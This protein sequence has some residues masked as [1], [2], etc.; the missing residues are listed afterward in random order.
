MLL[1]RFFLLFA[2]LT[3]AATGFS[4]TS[5]PLAFGQGRS[6][7]LTSP[8]EVNQYTLSGVENGDE[9]LIRVA[10]AG[11]LQPVL[12]V[13]YGNQPLD[14]IEHA[15]L[16]EWTTTAIHSGS[17][18]LR[19][20]DQ[21]ADDSGMFSICA[22][23]LNRP[24][25]PEIIG[26]NT[27]LAGYLTYGADIKAFKIQLED[28][29]T[30]SLSVFTV[31]PD[32]IHPRLIV[33]DPTGVLLGSCS[34]ASACSILLDSLPAS[35]YYLF[36][37]DSTGANTGVFYLEITYYTGGCV[38]KE[39]AITSS[40]D[41]LIVIPGGSAIV[42]RPLCPGDDFTLTASYDAP[43]ALYQWT[44]PD[45]F[46]AT[47]AEFARTDISGQ[48]GGWYTVS[49]YV[50]GGC[51][52]TASFYLDVR[53]PSVSIDVSPGDDGVVCAG[54][55][56]TLAVINPVSTNYH[57]FMPNGSTIDGPNIVI[58][59]IDT[60]QAG[61]YRVSAYFPWNLPYING[62][63]V[64]TGEQL[65]TVLPAPTVQAIVSG[66]DIIPSASGG[67]G[68]Y[69]YD[70]T[71]GY[72]LVDGRFQNLPQGH[73]VITVTDANGC[74]ATSD[75]LVVAVAEPSAAFGLTLTPNPG[76]GIFRLTCTDL[77]RLPLHLSLYDA[78]GLP[79]STFDLH[80]Q[81]LTLDLSDLPSGWY[82]I[83]IKDEM[84]V[85]ALRLG[86]VR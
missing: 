42:Q 72:P 52:S 84:Q 51:Q 49:A 16:A 6:D 82:L 85:G 71:G 40:T 43:D 68:P 37:M 12:E 58:A 79:L 47:G 38:D 14:T 32:A 13:W 20:R 67:A 25:E 69:S 3:V 65:I 1:K 11:S 48:A 57:W 44:G 27:G 18:T 17:Y 60:L 73:Y 7:S 23:R 55:D 77:L 86:I 10:S 15:F 80:H 83:R 5:Q 9:L 19:V 22:Q 50:P 30:V 34:A 39:V 46:T 53:N 76:S 2:W 26:C 59:D 31:S 41:V 64:G 29:T 70:I 61:L 8:T 21:G 24:A 36:A 63:C 66:H 81:D 35:C 45:G 74:T 28:E 33:T 54:S 78:T 62:G 75:N 4:Q 56:L